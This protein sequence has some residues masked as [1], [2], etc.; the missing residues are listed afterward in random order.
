MRYSSR[1]LTM[2]SLVSMSVSV[3]AQSNHVESVFQIPPNIAKASFDPH[4]VKN[5]TKEFGPADVFIT[6]LDAFDFEGLFDT[7]TLTSDGAN[8]SINGGSV[9]QVQTGISLPSGVSI[10]RI[11][12]EGCDNNASAELSVFILDI[13][14][15]HQGGTLLVP[16]NL[17]FAT[18]I[19]AADGCGLYSK[20]L[21][22]PLIIDNLN[23]TYIAAI[24][25]SDLLNLT[26]FRAFRL[27]WRRQVSPPPPS[28][29]FNDVLTSHP[30]FNSIEAMAASGITGG[31]GGGNYCPDDPLTRGQMAAFLAR[32]LGLHFP[33]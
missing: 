30:F 2:L 19:T 20:T 15:P 29:T 21:I 27:F 7:T 3:V 24:S 25:D 28:P 31:C 18:G 4:R 16:T 10:E 22:P 23:Y 33:N 17:F 26:N 13:L 11:E 5:T 1:I 12:L 32:A 14:T 9:T 8:R 6:T